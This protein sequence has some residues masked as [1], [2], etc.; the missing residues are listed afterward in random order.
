M[1]ELSGNVTTQIFM[2]IFFL[3][4]YP[5][6]HSTYSVANAILVGGCGFTSSLIGGY[7]SDKYSKDNPRIKS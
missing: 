6:F 2:P 3:Q 7:I 1:F 5:E 4:R